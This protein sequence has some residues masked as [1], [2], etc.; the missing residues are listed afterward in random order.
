[1]LVH[2]LHRRPDIKPA[3]AQRL[4]LAGEALSAGINP[5]N[6]RR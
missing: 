4:A 2:R 3:E 5:A 6:T 1:M